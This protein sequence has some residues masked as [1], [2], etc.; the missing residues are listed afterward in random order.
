MQAS[1]Q[2]PPRP[3]G[4][5]TSATI[6]DYAKAIYSLERRADGVTSTGALAERLEITAGAASAMVS[7]LAERGLVTHAPYRGISLTPPG[8]RV[9]LK[10]LRRHRLLETYLAQELGMSWDRVHA[11]AELLE[12]VLSEELEALIAAKLGHPT[13]DPHGD[14]IPGL[15]LAFDEPSSVSL[16]SLEPG[17]AGVFSRV[18]D[19]DPEML[20]YLAESGIAPG[21]RFEIVERQPFGGPVFARFAGGVHALGGA[22]A[23]RMR[24]E[25]RDEDDL[26]A[27]QTEH[28][29]R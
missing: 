20:R 10:V 7:K 3:H 17:T 27:E 1:P 19:S 15:E 25:V 2:H 21:D 22:L 13:H 5:S 11:E 16:A 18:S 9:A 28:D 12:H 8:T 24:A 4:G 6:E 29:Q 23:E 14:P 26:A